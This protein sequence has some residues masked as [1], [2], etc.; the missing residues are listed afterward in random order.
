[1]YTDSLSAAN[2]CA[3]FNFT[4]EIG[5]NEFIIKVNLSDMDN[6][7]ALIGYLQSNGKSEILQILENWC[8]D[9]QSDGEEIPEGFED[10]ILEIITA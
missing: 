9:F 7:H 3:K 4:Y 10:E 8:Q 2:L 5:D 1:V 6:F